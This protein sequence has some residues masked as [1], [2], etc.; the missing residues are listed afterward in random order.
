M[1]KEFCVC[2]DASVEGLGVVFMQDGGVITYASRK[3]KTHEINYATHD[4]ELVA[5]VMAL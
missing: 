5:V 2:I 3:L 1:D 4:L